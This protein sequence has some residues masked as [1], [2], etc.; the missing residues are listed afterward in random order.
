MATRERVS[1]SGCPSR[2]KVSLSLTR[3]PGRT[4]RSAQEPTG[5]RGD[6]PDHPQ[7]VCG[8]LRAR[9]RPPRPRASPAPRRRGLGDDTDTGKS[10]AA[11][12]P[13][14]TGGVKVTKLSRDSAGKS[15]L[16][17]SVALGREAVMPWTDP[18]APGS[19]R[20]HRSKRWERLAARLPQVT[21]TLGALALISADKLLTS[22]RGVTPAWITGAPWRLVRVR[23]FGSPLGYLAVC[24]ATPPGAKRCSLVHP[25]RSPDRW[26]L[27]SRK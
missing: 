5:G 2:V 10:G 9:S 25:K 7:A 8:R 22:S 11:C 15:A 1:W 27:P 16:S 26:F 3:A 4:A 17:L 18:T 12:G 13:E 24:G 14:T 6:A 23:G 19:R 20:R 21:L